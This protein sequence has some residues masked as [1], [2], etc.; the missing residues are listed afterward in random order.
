MLNIVRNKAIDHQRSISRRDKIQSSVEDVD[1]HDGGYEINT[2]TIGLQRE[3]KSL[4]N[5]KRELI[6]L[7]YI[8]GYSHREIAERKNLPLGTVKTRI[9]AAIGELKKVFG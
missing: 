7:S 3:L 1:V 4:D 6:E 5:D 8:L 2:D 9:R